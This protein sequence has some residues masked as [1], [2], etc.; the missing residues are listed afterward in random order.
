[1]RVSADD[2]V[3]AMLS[4]ICFFFFF[5]SDGDTRYRESGCVACVSLLEGQ[6]QRRYF[7]LEGKAQDQLGQ[8]EKRQKRGEAEV[9][10]RRR[11]KGEEQK[12]KS[13]SS[14]WGNVEII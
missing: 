6:A 7:L 8:T 4:A 11:T 2:G 9:V 10:N 12:R 1:M 3:P 13:T 14:T 5:G